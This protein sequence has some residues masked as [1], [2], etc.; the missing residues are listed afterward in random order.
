MPLLSSETV[1][2]DIWDA[3]SGLACGAVLAESNRQDDLQK[4]SHSVVTELQRPETLLASSA[5][6]LGTRAYRR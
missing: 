2:Y 1:V 3:L 4:Y 5:D 6:I